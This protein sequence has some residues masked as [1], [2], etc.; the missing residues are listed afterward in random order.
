MQKVIS[1]DIL[2]LSIN[3]LL[4]IIVGLYAFIKDKPEYVLNLPSIDDIERIEISK[5]ENIILVATDEAVEKIINLLNNKKTKSES[6][7]DYPSNTS[8]LYKINFIHKEIGSSTIYI[9][10]IKNN[11]YVEQPYNGIYEIAESEYNKILS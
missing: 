1:K 4:I 11:Y 5:N 8:E 7:T 2:F 9:Y 6:I 10:R 3:L